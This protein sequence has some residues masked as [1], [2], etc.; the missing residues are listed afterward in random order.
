MSNPTAKPV[1]A[2]TLL[3][4]LATL[5]FFLLLAWWARQPAV[6]PTTVAAENLTEDLKWK[7]TPETRKAYLTELR[8]NEKK[9]ATSYAW[10][11]EK[12]GVVQLPIDRA[13]EL[14]VQKYGSGK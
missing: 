11:N 3:A 1:S 8:A 6:S 2:F 14:T 7:A 9:H 12:A 10:V 13:M 5:G 4:V